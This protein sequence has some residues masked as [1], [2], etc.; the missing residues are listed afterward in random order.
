MEQGVEWGAGEFGG[1][2]FEV[3]KGNFLLGFGDV[4]HAVS[5]GGG[6][7]GFGLQHSGIED[8]VGVIEDASGEGADESSG[9]AIS[10]AA[11]GNELTVELVVFEFFEELF[12][13]EELGIAFSGAEA[14]PDLGN[15][16]AD[17][18][19]DADVGTDVTGRCGEACESGEE[20]AD[21]CI[22]EVGDGSEAVEG[23]FGES[24]FAAGSGGGGTFAGEGADKVHEE[25]REFLIVDG[26][27]DCERSNAFGGF[28]GIITA[29][30]E[31]GLHGG[32]D[33][34]VEGYGAVE[35][36]AHF[37][38]VAIDGVD[39]I[40]PGLE[41]AWVLAGD[42]VDK[43]WCIGAD[44]VAVAAFQHILEEPL[45]GLCEL[46]EIYGAIAD[47]AD[48]FACEGFE[49]D[50]EVVRAGKVCFCEAVESAVDSVIGALEEAVFAVGNEFV[51]EF[52]GENG[53]EVLECAAWDDDGDTDVIFGLDFLGGCEVLAEFPGSPCVF[54]EESDAEV[55]TDEATF[56]EFKFVSGM[57]VDDIDR[58]VAAPVGF[59]AGVH[60]FDNE[61]DG[62]DV[63]GDSCEPL[64]VVF[65]VVGG[66]CKEFDDAA[67]RAGGVED[68]AAG[69]AVVVG[70][71]S[72]I[73]APAIGIIA[74]EDLL[75]E[76]EVFFGISDKDGT[77]EE[78]VI[79]G[80]ADFAF[81]ATTDGAGFVAKD[82]FEEGSYEPPGG[83]CGVFFE[84]NFVAGGCD[85]DVAWSQWDVLGFAVIKPGDS[86]V[87]NGE[88][89]IFRDVDDG[90]VYF[91]DGVAFGANIEDWSVVAGNIGKGAIVVASAVGIEFFAEV[92]AGEGHCAAGVFFFD[93]ACEVGGVAELGFDF[94]L[95]VA[96]VVIGDEGDDDAFFIA[97]GEFEGGTV[98]VFFVFG[99]PAH[100]VLSLAFGGFFVVGQSE[101][102]FGEVDEVWCEDNATGVTAP[103]LHIDC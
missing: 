88:A 64:I 59:G 57:S 74:I 25:L 97:A 66:W 47:F 87:S 18:V 99:F 79:D 36:D 94:F 70:L 45:H 10:E 84:P 15:Q 9:D 6:V 49:V 98:V 55:G 56:A 8:F 103:V 77:V 67:E 48:L 65:G 85:I 90:G 50:D 58:E 37:A 39:E 7:L 23:S 82:A 14:A 19:I 63:I 91:I 3:A 34:L 35:T 30:N 93:E 96:V 71:N 22:I 32:V 52:F 46:A 4:E 13:D 60:T 53:T 11:G 100:A 17:V 92:E 33:G 2:I 78:V 62:V 43:A 12:A 16:Q 26:V 51:A 41:V 75:H 86:L 80:F 61:D 101:F 72:S 24:T 69:G 102:T 28:W 68:T 21:E 44:E 73:G 1:A 95:A 54:A 31:D 38:D 83:C 5:K 42:A 20:V 27:I 89:S 40:R 81:S 29:A 76:F